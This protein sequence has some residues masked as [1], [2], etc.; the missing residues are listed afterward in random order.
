MLFLQSSNVIIARQ[1]KEGHRKI[2]DHVREV[3][4]K[5]RDEVLKGRTQKPPADT[6]SD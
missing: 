4:K 3:W 1:D 2:A 6:P 5:Y